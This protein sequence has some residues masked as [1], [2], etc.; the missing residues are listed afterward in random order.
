MK[1]Y[2]YQYVYDKGFGCGVCSSDGSSFP[3]SYIVRNKRKA[4]IFATISFWK[5]I[6]YYEFKEMNEIIDEIKKE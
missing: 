6:S 5:E 1:Y 2:Y 4:N 3:L